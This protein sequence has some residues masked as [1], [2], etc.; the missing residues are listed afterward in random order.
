MKPMRTEIIARLQHEFLEEMNK[1]N[2]TLS[3]SKQ[4]FLAETVKT[5]LLEAYIYG[6]DRDWCDDLDA[7]MLSIEHK[8]KNND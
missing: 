7:Y 4:E 1:L 8:E 3:K 6:A 5:Y 2:I